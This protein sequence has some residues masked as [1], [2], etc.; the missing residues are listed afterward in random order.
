MKNNIWYI[1]HPLHRYNEDAKAL[2]RA[3]GLRIVD[4]N[5]VPKDERENAAEKTP[6]LTVAKPADE[7]PA[8]PA[9][10][11]ES[12]LGAR[13]VKGADVAAEAPTDTTE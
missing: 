13:K 6:K 3:A 4:A 10:E 2:A 9:T 12:P 11:P 5:V 7:A 1:E 8:A